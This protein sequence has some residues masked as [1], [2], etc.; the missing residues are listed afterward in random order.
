M[1]EVD[2]QSDVTYAEV[3]GTVLSLDLHR[4]RTPSPPPVVVYLH[5]GAWQVGDKAEGAAERLSALA[6]HGIAVVSANYRL[7]E[8][9]LYPAQIHDAKAAV[10]WVRA[11]GD[12]HGL[13]TERVGIWG[14][15]AGGYLASMVGLTADDP[16]LEGSVGDAATNASAV[17]AVVVWFGQSDLA[18]SARRSGLETMILE[19]PVEPPLFGL[20]SAEQYPDRLRD[21]SPLARVHAAAPPFLIAHGDR[22]R[23]TPLLESFTLHDRLVREG[24]NSALLTV[25]GAGHEGAEFDA[26][27]NL[28]ITAA[29]LM[30]HLS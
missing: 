2:V 17:D 8:A 1:F 11:H 18:G 6:A 24:R 25:G 15:S 27:A 19:P 26:P 23:V 21:A 9:A 16:E 14:A 13:A 30:T 3:E 22:D 10:R 20:D 4:P 12:E 7:I 5:G 29:F 28:A